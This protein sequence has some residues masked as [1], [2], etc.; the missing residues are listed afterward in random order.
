ML[1]YQRTLAILPASCEPDSFLAESHVLITTTVE[2]LIST[3]PQPQ[4]HFKN[5]LAGI[6]I[7]QSIVDKLLIGCRGLP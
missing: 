4:Q 3:V 2:Y 7:I 1:S 6:A 5:S